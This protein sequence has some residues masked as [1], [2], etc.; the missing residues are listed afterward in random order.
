MAKCAVIFCERE[1]TWIWQPAGPS[2]QTLCF[3][4]PGS[5]YRGFAA[6]PLC[7]ECKQA[8]ERGIEK[9]IVYHGT[10]YRYCA[11]EGE[12]KTILNA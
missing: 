9:V 12:V 2:E 5:H 3:V 7:E 1:R 8:V 4:V 6:I 11:Q 10:T